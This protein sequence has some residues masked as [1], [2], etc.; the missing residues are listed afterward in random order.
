MHQSIGFDVGD[1]RIL[2]QGLDDCWG[3]LSGESLECVA[4]AMHCADTM[5]DAQVSYDVVYTGC[6]GLQDDDIGPVAVL[7]A[8]S[9]AEQ[10]RDCGG[11]RGVIGE[12]IGTAKG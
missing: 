1:S 7:P 8:W 12:V 11:R 5:A 9:L 3:E 10:R 4:V 6:R 2:P